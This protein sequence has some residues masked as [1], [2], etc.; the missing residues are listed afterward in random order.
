MD[1]QCRGC[2]G[3]MIEQESD[4]DLNVRGMAIHVIGLRHMECIQCGAQIETAAQVDYNHMLV[5]LACGHE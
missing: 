5:K 1:K 3:T 4:Q 2:G